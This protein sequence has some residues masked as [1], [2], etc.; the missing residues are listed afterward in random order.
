MLREL[1]V[2]DEVRLKLERKVFGD[3]SDQVRSRDNR[4]PT[5]FYY[6]TPFELKFFSH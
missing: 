4:Q 3:W 2:M 1:I 5:T 6:N